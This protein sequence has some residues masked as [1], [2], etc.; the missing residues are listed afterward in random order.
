M[1][2][3]YRR[4]EPCGLQVWPACVGQL[5]KHHTPRCVRHLLACLRA[6]GSLERQVAPKC[7]MCVMA[8]ALQSDLS[9][10]HPIFLTGHKHQLKNITTGTKFALTSSL[11][12]SDNCFTGGVPKP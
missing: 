9:H 6:Q 5:P 1:D 11:V 10:L 8:S 12:L 3:E 4:D 2:A 7:H